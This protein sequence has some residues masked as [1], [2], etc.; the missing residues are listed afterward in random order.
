VVRGLGLERGYPLVP[1]IAFTPYVAAAG[2]VILL[3]DVLAR[4]WG[5][6]VVALVSV[7]VLAAGVVPRAVGDAAAAGGPR[8]RVLTANLH[9]GTVEAHAVVELVRRNDVDVLSVQELS[10]PT[11]ARLRS[12]GLQRVLPHAVLHPGTGGGG[13]GLYARIPLQARPPLPSTYVHA[14]AVGRWQGRSV[15][16]V[17]VHPPPPTRR[18]THLWTADLR[19]LPRASAPGSQVLAG[20]FNATL[21]HAAMRSLLDSGYADAA[22]SV[23]AGW[24]ATWPHGRRW[25]LGVA[26]DHVLADDHWSVRDVRLF[27]LPGSDHRPLLAEMVE[28]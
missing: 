27:T 20:D 2:P 16:F 13:T 6:S 24:R 26:I 17:A 21:D 23:G 12:A 11:A 25:P 10:A 3:A 8:L 5:A 9:F 14:V 28:R 7:A 19:R 22:A 15:E 1:L 4:R 18:R